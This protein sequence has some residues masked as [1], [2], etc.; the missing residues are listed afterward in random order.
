MNLGLTEH[1][2]VTPKVI[3]MNEISELFL[4]CIMLICLPWG[5]VIELIP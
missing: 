4:N 3:I 2:E 1:E 5:E